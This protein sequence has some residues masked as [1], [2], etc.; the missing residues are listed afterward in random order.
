M[1]TESVLHVREVTPRERH[2]LILRNIREARQLRRTD[3][4]DF[5]VRRV[6]ARD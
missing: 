5:A 3:R 2:P 4:S 1:A 6:V